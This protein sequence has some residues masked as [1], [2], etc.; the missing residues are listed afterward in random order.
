MRIASDATEPT[1]KGRSLVYDTSSA[2]ISVTSQETVD[3]LFIAVRPN[4]P[5]AHTVQMSLLLPHQQPLRAGST[6]SDVITDWSHGPPESAPQFDV[7]FDNLETAVGHVGCTFQVELKRIVLN[8]KGRVLSAWFTF[9]IHAQGEVG[10]VRGEVQ[11]HATSTAK[12]FN[13]PPVVNLI[14]EPR[15]ETHVPTR[16]YAEMY[17]DG[18][19]RG[20][21]VSVLWSLSP[22]DGEISEEN[23]L[24][25]VV[26]LH[27]LFALPGPRTCRLT[28]T[29]SD[30][31]KTTVKDYDIACEPPYA[32]TILNASGPVSSPGAL[33]GVDL[34]GTDVHL[35][36]SGTTV[37]TLNV[38][39]KY[40]KVQ[41]QFRADPG[42]LALP[43]GRY[44]DPST[45][46]DLSPPYLVIQT[47]GAFLDGFDHLGGWFEI[48]KLSSLT[49]GGGP[50][51]LTFVEYQQEDVVPFI[52]E[53]RSQVDA[54]EAVGLP[55]LVAAGVNRKLTRLSKPM[56][57]G[58]A[59]GIKG[60]S[61]EPLRLKWT[62][63]SGPGDVTFADD[64]AGETEVSFSVEGNYVLRLTATQGAQSASDDV[65]IG[66][67]TRETSLA[68]HSY[69][70]TG[71]QGLSLVDGVKVVSSSSKRGD[72]EAAGKHFSLTMA[73]GSPIQP[74]VY[75][76]ETARLTWDMEDAHTGRITVSEWTLDANGRLAGA[77][78][79]FDCRLEDGSA[80]HSVGEV[81]Y[82]AAAPAPSVNQAPTVK[83]PVPE[84]ITNALDAQVT[85]ELDDDLLP[86]PG[87]VSG[88][89][90]LVSGPGKVTFD[91]A[92]VIQTRVHFSRPGAYVLRFSA[93]DGELR[94]A[95]DLQVVAAPEAQ[96]YR[97]TILQE[98]GDLVSTF[99]LTTTRLGSFTLTLGPGTFLDGT[100][101][102][103]IMDG[104]GQVVISPAATPGNDVGV[105]FTLAQSRR[106]LS[107][108]LFANGLSW[109][110]SG[111]EGSGSLWRA[112]RRTAPRAGRYTWV[113]TKAADALTLPLHAVG[114]MVVDATGHVRMTGT[115]PDGQRV[116]S[117]GEYGLDESFTFSGSASD[118]RLYLGSFQ[119]VPFAETAARKQDFE[120]TL[121]WHCFADDIHKRFARTDSLVGARYTPPANG[122][123]VLTL[124]AES[125]ALD[126]ALN[127]YSTQADAFSVTLDGANHLV[128]DRSG[129]QLAVDPKTG[130]FTGTWT[131]SG[132][133]A[134]PVHGA[135]L[136]PL[137]Q[138]FGWAGGVGGYFGVE[139]TTR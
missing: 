8:E 133:P 103:R 112:T 129:L 121:K 71:T 69:Y 46:G 65:T 63:V 116:S 18:L 72:F 59:R 84:V 93:D 89:W 45:T 34:N 43:I 87:V 68:F 70:Q 27:P 135:F 47:F 81:R 9:E 108:N 7:F 99:V 139:V 126:V 41:W 86:R 64:T 17:D 79:S 109:T 91:E 78:F 130:L 12:P 82:L 117:G 76:P 14:S 97:G 19:P 35:D 106:T 54:P 33:N 123:N 16:L 57:H 29:V 56:L 75:T 101:K 3:A 13:F 4:V 22:F 107:G 111:T 61:T 42:G 92:D 48:R 26:T 80:V 24:Y 104:F 1:L 136:Q 88:G 25:P 28:L 90:S 120:G 38:T 96:T 110:M 40:E 55:P 132:K 127:A 37:G 30:G 118:R 115:L 138:G 98:Q 20:G 73:D 134:R 137:Q 105:A 85:A 5:K 67:T 52:G 23:S 36:F 66:W 15:A 51:W 124:G 60:A 77:R 125:L 44:Q 128:A 114:A 113:S 62:V 31:E 102:G 11:W 100:Y 32:Q 122:A 39:A 119:F 74:G 58:A 21:I 2:T 49:P 83:M 94:A 131:M 10:G 50:F 53:L 95:A 6:Y